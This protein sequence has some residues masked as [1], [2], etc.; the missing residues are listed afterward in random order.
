MA[1]DLEGMGPRIDLEAEDQD[2]SQPAPKSPYQTSRSAKSASSLPTMLSAGSLVVALLAGVLGIWA[3]NSTP[4]P[5]AQLPMP[6]AEV[7]PGGAA[8]RVAKLEK[9]VGNLMLRIVTLE[10]ELQAVAGKTGG[11]TKITELTAKV[12]ALQSRLDS[13][14]VGPKSNAVMDTSREEEKPRPAPKAAPRSEAPART[15]TPARTEAPRRAETPRPAPKPA[16]K[17]ESETNSSAKKIKLVYTVRR[18]DTLF[19]VARRHSVT[20]EDLMRWNSLQPGANLLVDQQL[21]IFK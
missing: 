5:A 16:A 4:P 6:P 2:F 11:V 19:S 9:D 7:V 20:T 13:M 18:G 3:L 14:G 12:A 8:E 10:K 21:V 17:A 15:E 1:S